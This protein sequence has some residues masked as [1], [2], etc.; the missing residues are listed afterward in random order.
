MFAFE[1]EKELI[2]EWLSLEGY[3]VETNVTLMGNKKIADIIAVRLGED[4]S[5][6]WHIEIGN[7]LGN[8]NRNKEKIANKFDEYKLRAIKRY[9]KE[10][11]PLTGK[12]EYR[13]T[14]IANYC[15]RFKELKD[16]L[17]E[18]GIELLLLSDLAKYEIPESIRRWKKRQQ[19][20][21]AV[22][23]WETMALPRKYTLLKVIELLNDDL[24]PYTHSKQ[25]NK[26]RYFVYQ[27]TLN[28]K[29]QRK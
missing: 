7:L 21:G 17:Q 18:M 11:L 1:W 13:R 22:K 4:K 25:R 10:K 19:I 15:T 9:L 26:Y 12:T 24:N 2:A 5:I 20:G 28:F 29:S 6:V 27:K 23:D 8:L 14:F 3:L 16:E